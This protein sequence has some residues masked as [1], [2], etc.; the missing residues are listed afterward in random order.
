MKVLQGQ[1]FESRYRD[2]TN[3]N[4]GINPN[5]NNHTA[6]TPG[7]ECTHHEVYSQGQV[8]FINDS[9]GYHKVGNQDTTHLSM[10]LHL[11]A[12]PFQQCRTWLDP[13]NSQKSSR[14]KMCFYSAYGKVL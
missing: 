9:M 10:T 12:P 14:S 3:E 11:Y 4:A 2:V 1:V 5:N 13:N 8:A 6:T 7:L